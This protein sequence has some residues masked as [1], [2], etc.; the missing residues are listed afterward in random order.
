VVLSGRDG[1]RGDA[2]D[3]ALFW[4]QWALRTPS[5]EQVAAAVRAASAQTLRRRV[6]E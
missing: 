1:E 4:Q 6:E 5:L 2:E 3:V